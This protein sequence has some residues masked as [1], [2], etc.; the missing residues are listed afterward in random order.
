MSSAGIGGTTDAGKPAEVDVR[1]HVRTDRKLAA[2]G[3]IG[4]QGTEDCVNGRLSDLFGPVE[5]IVPS[6]RDLGERPGVRDVERDGSEVD[7]PS[8]GLAVVTEVPGAQHRDAEVAFAPGEFVVGHGDGGEDSAADTSTRGLACALE[9]S[10]FLGVQQMPFGD[11]NLSAFTLGQSE[12]E[13]ETGHLPVVF[14]EC[15]SPRG[16]FG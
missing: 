4:G 3:S 5:P 11:S 1:E 16:D 2:Q 13:R 14:C 15:V 12:V 8:L 10:S 9:S 7:E 6:R